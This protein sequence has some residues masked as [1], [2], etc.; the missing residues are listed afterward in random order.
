MNTK[1]SLASLVVL[2]SLC[3]APVAGAQ[4]RRAARG[5]TAAATGEQAAVRRCFVSYK[6]AILKQN[7]KE[8][9]RFVNQATVAY[10]GKMRD[11]AL[12]G[13]ETDVRR[14]PFFHKMMIL[15]YRH[16]VPLDSLL[17][18]SAEEL[19]VYGVDKGWIGRESVSESNLGRVSVSGEE[20]RAVFV[21][22]GKPTPIEYRFTKE[23]GAWKLD[24]ISLMPVV[25]AAFGA[26]AREANVDED[27]FVVLLLELAS[28]KKVSPDIWQPLVK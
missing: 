12:G 8:S 11:L 22:R 28:G 13:A 26:A 15:S 4:K 5:Q 1:A 7:G 6:E 24:F 20:A 25:D 10:F 16:R 17:K 19:F 9:V 2:L 14:L 21:L 18:L 3:C 27:S 23:G